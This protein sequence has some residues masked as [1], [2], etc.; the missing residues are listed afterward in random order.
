MG[1]QA[2]HR[3]RLDLRTHEDR[4]R[5][6]T[7][8]PDG[9]VGDTHGNGIAAEQALMQKLDSGAFDEAQLNQAAFEF[10]GRQ[11]RAATRCIDCMYAATKAHAG[12][13]KCYGWMSMHCE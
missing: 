13:T 3:T 11:T 7:A 4:H 6:T 10:F 2:K 5:F 12:G 1:A 8:Q 9:R